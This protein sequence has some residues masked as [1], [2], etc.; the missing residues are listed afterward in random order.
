MASECLS[1]RLE[2]STQLEK[3]VGS[4]EEC[5]DIYPFLRNI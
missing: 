5:F 1:R 3:R 2:L 4:T